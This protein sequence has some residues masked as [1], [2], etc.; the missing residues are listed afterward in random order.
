MKTITIGF[1]TSERWLSKLIRWMSGSKIS[2]SYIKIPIPDF[3]EAMVFQASGLTVNYTN[4]DIFKH[5][6]NVIA[7]YELE[8][9]EGQ[10]QLAEWVRITEAGKPYAVKQLFGYVLVLLCRKAGYQVPNPFADGAA[11]HSCIELVARSLGLEN[12]ESML[13]HDL[14]KLIREGKLGKFRRV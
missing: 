5:E 14:E 8:V 7:E 1:S 12:V 13:P 9:T 4:Y 2:H 3:N 6:A 10:F 11:A